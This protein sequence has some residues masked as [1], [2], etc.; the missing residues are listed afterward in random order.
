VATSP[1][2]TFGPFP[3]AAVNIPIQGICVDVTGGAVN[4]VLPVV[5]FVI[6]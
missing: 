5:H 1:E 6:N 4:A 3:V 2:R